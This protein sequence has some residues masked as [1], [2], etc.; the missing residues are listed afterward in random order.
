MKSIVV[1]ITFLIG[2]SSVAQTVNQKDS[3]G[4]KQGPWQKN[5]PKSKAF[6]YT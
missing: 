1:F 4:R 2:F 6:E 5:Y 3:Q